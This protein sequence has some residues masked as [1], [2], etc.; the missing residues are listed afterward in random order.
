[1]SRHV[2]DLVGVPLML[3]PVLAEDLAL[4]EP[5]APGGG[6]VAIPSASSLAVGSVFG[7]FSDIQVACQERLRQDNCSMV[8]KNWPMKVPKGWKEEKPPRHQGKSRF[9]FTHRKGYFACSGAIHLGA[10]PQGSA[11]PSECTFFVPYSYTHDFV[12][13][14]ANAIATLRNRLYKALRA[15]A[16]VHTGFGLVV[17]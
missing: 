16:R 11:A 9:H 12:S 8:H 2:E 5:Y 10:K 15:L 3:E 7:S 6:V 17:C 14:S 4:A 13:D 1:M